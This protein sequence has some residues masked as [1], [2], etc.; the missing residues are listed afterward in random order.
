MFNL[1]EAVKNVK[2]G[3]GAG[4]AIKAASYD[5]AGYT[6]DFMQ[7]VGGAIE[8]FDRTLRTKDKESDISSGSEKR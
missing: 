8:K 4:D 2:K 6:G 5:A 7:I 3:M 1:D